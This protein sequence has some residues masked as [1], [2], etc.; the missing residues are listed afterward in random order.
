M[1]TSPL[2]AALESSVGRSGNRHGFRIRQA[3]PADLENLAVIDHLATVHTHFHC[4][5]RFD[6][7][8]PEEWT[9]MFR[10]DELVRLV[11]VRGRVPAGF[12]LASPGKGLCWKIGRLAVDPEWHHNGVGTALICELVR[13][14]GIGQLSAIVHERCSALLAF[15]RRLGFVAQRGLL[16]NLFG[17]GDG[18]IMRWTPAEGE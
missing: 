11:A 8:P 7:L 18:I 16:Q 13:E 2:Q 4:G 12:V 3:M 17:D 5:A 15:Y 14:Q 10:D 9:A 1:K 6:D